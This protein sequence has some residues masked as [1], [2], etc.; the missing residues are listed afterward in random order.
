MKAVLVYHNAEIEAVVLT[1][2]VAG[3]K[4]IA[5]KTQD[6]YVEQDCFFFFELLEENLKASNLQYTFVDVVEAFEG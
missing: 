2:D 3:V 4:E 6:E 1:D 5:E